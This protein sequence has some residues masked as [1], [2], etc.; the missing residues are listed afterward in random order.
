MESASDRRSSGEDPR[1][2]PRRFRIHPI[3]GLNLRCF[4]KAL[5]LG[6]VVGV[7]APPHR[8]NETVV[9]EHVNGTLNLTRASARCVT[10][11][12][13]G[14]LKLA[15]SVILRQSLWNLGHFH[16]LRMRKGEACHVSEAISRIR[17]RVHAFGKNGQVSQRAQGLSTEGGSLAAGR[18]SMETA[19]PS[20]TT[21]TSLPQSVRIA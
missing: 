5:C 6:V 21:L 4:H 19:P 10:F 12:P 20:R 7:P 8:T 2:H 16:E 15:A 9:G 18:R 17:G 14:P 3:D 11:M 13:Y 1:S